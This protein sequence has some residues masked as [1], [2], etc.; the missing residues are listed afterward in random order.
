MAARALI[1]IFRNLVLCLAF[2]THQLS[3]TAA[4]PLEG[5]VS[6]PVVEDLPPGPGEGRRRRNRRRRRH[7]RRPA[8]VPA[9]GPARWCFV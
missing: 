7:D 1:L 6:K 8:S 4:A 9:F 2:V 3:L 5:L